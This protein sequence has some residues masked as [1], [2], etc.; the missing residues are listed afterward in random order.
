MHYNRALDAF[1]ML[2]N[3]TAAGHGDL[4]QEG[5]YASMNHDLADAEGWS[6]PLQIV[7]G[8]AWY[9]QAVGLEEGCGDTEVGGVCRFFMAGY[10]AW[11]I[12]FTQAAGRPLANRPLICTA[13]Q[14]ATLFGADRR[15]PW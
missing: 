11:E 2:L 5:I 10:S 14:F 13:Q 6:P 8:G 1:V 15:C 7:R 12:E 4:P 9:P 3:R